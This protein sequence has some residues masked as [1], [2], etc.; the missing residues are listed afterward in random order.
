MERRSFRAMGTSI[1]LLVEAENAGSELD[2]C[3]AEF[4]R[5]EQVMSRFRPD[6]ELSR[7]NRAGGI[8]ASRDLAEVVELA[9]AARER[10]GGVFDPTV[11]RALEAAGYD[12][13]FDEVAPDAGDG[14]APAPCGGG[15][16][17]VGR[18]IE[19][20]D[21][22]RARSRRY[23]QRLRGRARGRASRAHRSRASSTRAAT[24]PCAAHPKAGVWSIRSTTSSLSVSRPAASP[25]RAR[26]ASLAPGRR[27]AS[28]S[29]RPEHGPPCRHR[30]R[31]RDGGRFRRDRRRDPREV[32][33]L[34]RL[35]CC[36]R[37]RRSGGAR[38]R[39][40]G[41]TRTTGGLGS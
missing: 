36:A 8:D 16:V 38:A 5:L 12:R 10:T 14:D 40:R 22:I 4:E 30:H 34:R 39:G 2:A 17:V 29:H 35:G 15:V 31:A 37:R 27:G 6:S 9:I 13:T 1:E 18:R 41:S 20:E 28:P 33:L 19:V 7:L 11:H 24:S 26:P 23:R 21:G 3:E 25:P 32:A